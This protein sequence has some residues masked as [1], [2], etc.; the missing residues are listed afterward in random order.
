MKKLDIHEHLREDIRERGF[1]TSRRSP[2]DHRRDFS[3]LDIPIYRLSWSDKMLLP[4]N[5]IE[6][7][8]TE[9]GRKWR[10]T[11]RHSVEYI[12]SPQR[13]NYLYISRRA[14][15][16]M[17]NMRACRTVPV[18]VSSSGT[19]GVPYGLYPRKSRESVF[20]L[21]RDIFADSSAL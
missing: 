4:D 18:K 2:E 9:E 1:S 21:V 12:R 11:M 15:F 5:I 14:F 8:R 3:H 19:S 6:C 20:P 16:H 10:E 7:T 13:S 17:S